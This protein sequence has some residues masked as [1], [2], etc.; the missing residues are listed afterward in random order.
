MSEPEPH[1]LVAIEGAPRL[2][3][4]AGVRRPT[5]HLPRAS[6][7][8]AMA[9]AG[10]LF[11]ADDETPP[12]EGRM[13]YL[14]AEYEDFMSRA[15]GQGRLLF[16]AGCFAISTLAP[17]LIRRGPGLLRLSVHDRVLALRAFEDTGLAGILIAVRAILCILYYEHAEVADGVGIPRGPRRG[18]R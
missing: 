12:P 11:S 6:V 13:V 1:P 8:R 2:P 18:R 15:T 10:A 7:D 4:P 14:R 5:G 17:I 16:R 3:G 9:I